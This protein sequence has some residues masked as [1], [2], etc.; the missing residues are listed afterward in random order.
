MEIQKNKEIIL[1]EDLIKNLSENQKSI[2]Q[3]LAKNPGGVLSRDLSKNGVANKSDTLKA[4]K[5]ILKEHGLEIQ[6]QR[7]PKQHQYL[8]SLHLIPSGET[9]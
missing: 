7:L 3:T 9:A 1:P 8:W 2:I 4:A 6:I 5:K